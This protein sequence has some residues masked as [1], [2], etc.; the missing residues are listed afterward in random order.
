MRP[1]G[2]QTVSTSRAPQRGS[3]RFSYAEREGS[4]EEPATPGRR[5]RPGGQ[6]RQVGSAI[7]GGSQSCTLPPP[8]PPRPPLSS[9]T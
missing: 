8:S 2:D 9:Q 7:E 1:A 6:Q 3:G 4:K 5:R